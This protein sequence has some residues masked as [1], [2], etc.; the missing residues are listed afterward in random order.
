MVVGIR[1]SGE[2]IGVIRQIKI[3]YQQNNKTVFK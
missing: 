1:V 2:G 3:K